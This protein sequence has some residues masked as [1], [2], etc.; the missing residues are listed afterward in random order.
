MITEGDYRVYV[1]KDGW[2]V[3]TVDQSWA[4]HVEDTILITNDGPVFLTR[5]QI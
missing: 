1:D 3:K 2:T 4:A 5:Q